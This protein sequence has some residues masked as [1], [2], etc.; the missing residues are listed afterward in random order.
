VTTK[1]QTLWP[2]KTEFIPTKNTTVEITR[3]ETL[4]CIRTGCHCCIKNALIVQNKRFI[5]LMKLNKQ[6]S[7]LPF[8]CNYKKN[9]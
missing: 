2:Y 8:F 7:L 1:T 3:L 4:F 6:I 9:K 5:D